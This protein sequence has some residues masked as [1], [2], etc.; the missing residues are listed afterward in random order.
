M[1]FITPEQVKAVRLKGSKLI[2]L[3]SIDRSVR[4]VKMASG[5]ALESGELNAEVK[6][7]KRR[8]S[9]LMLFLLEHACADEAGNML[10]HDDAATLFDI[11]PMNELVTI[12]NE[13][14]A[15][16]QVSMKVAD[17]EVMT[18]GKD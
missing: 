15:L 17:V 6:S 5:R 10:T 3:E 9:E 16:L 1:A 2:T 18:P 14:N 4:V 7:G 13:V 8:Q 11:L 12:V